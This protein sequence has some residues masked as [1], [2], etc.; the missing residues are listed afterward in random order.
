[1]E[2]FQ[3]PFFGSNAGAVTFSTHDQSTESEIMF[4]TISKRNQI[5][6]EGLITS[7]GLEKSSTMHSE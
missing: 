3:I 6:N 7:I 1:M 2:V 4:R 5:G